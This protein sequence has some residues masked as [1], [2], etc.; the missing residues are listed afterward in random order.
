MDPENRGDGRGRGVSA[1]QP[2]YVFTHRSELQLRIREEYEVVSFWL[3]RPHRHRGCVAP[4]HD[5][6]N[7]GGDPSERDPTPDRQHFFMTAH[8]TLQTASTWSGFHL[9]CM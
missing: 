5:P 4:S 6:A 1:R 2:R 9:Q 7:Y 8:F 3:A